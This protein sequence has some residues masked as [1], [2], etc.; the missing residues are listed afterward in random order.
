MCMHEHIH[1]IMYKC[2]HLHL[3]ANIYKHMHAIVYKC[4]HY[5]RVLNG[6]QG[7]RNNF[8]NNTNADSVLQRGLEQ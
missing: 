4:T 8:N 1:A 5:A 6:V 2:I 3:R 7:Y